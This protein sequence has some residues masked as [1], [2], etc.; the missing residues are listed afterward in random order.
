M[1]TAGADQEL[2]VAAARIKQATINHNKR[3]VRILGVLF[4]VGVAVGLAVWFGQVP[5]D[6]DSTH[7]SSAIA[8]GFGVFSIGC[9][10]L[11]VLFPR[12]PALCPKCQYDW[13][14][15]TDNSAS[16]LDWKHCPRC[17]LDLTLDGLPR[18]SNMK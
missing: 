15:Q 17:G 13:N 1:S 16:W 11:W 10:I 5:M 14:A 3:T 7:F 18:D 12:P 2:A 4:V 8:L 9:I 6:R